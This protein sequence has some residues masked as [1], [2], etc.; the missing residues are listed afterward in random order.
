MQT[1]L[2]LLLIGTLGMFYKSIHKDASYV[3]SHHAQF[4]LIW[5]STVVFA[6]IVKFK[7]L[8]YKKKIGYK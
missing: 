2:V 1:I 5:T 6:G 8:D 4:Y 7:I 3:N